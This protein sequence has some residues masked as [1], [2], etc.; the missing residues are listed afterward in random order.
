MG[1]RVVVVTQK[2]GAVFTQVFQG[3]N[4]WEQ[5][6]HDAAEALEFSQMLED[7]P[8]I[9]PFELLREWLKFHFPNGQKGRTRTERMQPVDSD[10]YLQ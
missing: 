8:A 7:N 4:V 2:G 5:Q 9:P 6:M 1:S 10:E 3:N